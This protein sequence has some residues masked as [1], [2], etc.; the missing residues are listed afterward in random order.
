ML[1]ILDNGH[2]INTA[3]KRSPEH[4]GMQ[5]FE[6][7]FNRD[8]VAR[9]YE[10]L[11]DEGHLVTKLVPEIEDVTLYERVKRANELHDDMQGNA[12]LVSIHAN[13][14]GGTGWEAYTYH[15]SS[16]ADS[17]AAELY[18]YAGHVL[19]GWRM[20]KDYTDGDCDKEAAFYILKHTKMP[21][22]LTENMFMD[23]TRDLEFL[24]STKGREKI[25]D[26]HYLGIKNY[27]EK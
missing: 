3:G 1:I 6:Y 20:R 10:R 7:E 2:G 4:K 23:T 21:A 22:V 13:A 26:V 24:M 15:G 9:L 27:L 18:Y 25:T 8:I 19:H 12:I 17:L 11:K 16:Q 5:L 14:G